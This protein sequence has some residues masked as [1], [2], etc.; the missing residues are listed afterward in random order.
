V[1]RAALDL[2]SLHW[3]ASLPWKRRP[4]R[5]SAVVPKALPVL[6]SCRLRLNGGQAHEG[7]CDILELSSDGVTIVLPERHAAR[8]GQQGQ[9]LIGPAEGSHYTV[10][11]AVRWVK[12]SPTATVLGLAFPETE[13][14]FYH[15]A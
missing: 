2:R 11:V 14:W 10:P 8:R 6:P 15:G 5:A 12:P 4:P 9:L 13:H 1:N 7:A 3:P